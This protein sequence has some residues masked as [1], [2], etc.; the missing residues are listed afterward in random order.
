MRRFV[1]LGAVASLVVSTAA[2]ASPVTI[3]AGTSVRLVTAQPL[4]SK[5]QVKGD[6]VALRTAEDVRVG[7]VV[8]VPKGTAATGQVAEARAKGAMGMAGRLEIRPLYLTLDGRT[9]RLAGAEGEHGGVQ[10]GA[11][12]GMLLVA[13]LFTGKSAVI[14]EGT[15]LRAVVAKTVILDR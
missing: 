14:P 8:A 7:D 5:T 15:P 1:A 9:V 2:A 4:S 10:P 11:I 6:L 12:L 13:P 3:P